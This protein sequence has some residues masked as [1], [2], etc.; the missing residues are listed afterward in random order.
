MFS[1]LARTNHPVNYEVD[2]VELVIPDSG[3]LLNEAAGWINTV[4]QTMDDGACQ[5]M[6]WTEFRGAA[7]YPLIWKGHFVQIYTHEWL[8]NRVIV[9]WLYWSS[10]T[11]FQSLIF[12]R[13]ASVIPFVLMDRIF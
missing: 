5:L 7:S 9:Y 6:L 2:N 10:P 3:I 1:A 8:S 4:G 13:Y 12:Q 11:L